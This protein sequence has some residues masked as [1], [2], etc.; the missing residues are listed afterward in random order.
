MESGIPIGKLLPAEKRK[1]YEILDT[2]NFW[3]DLGKQKTAILLRYRNDVFCIFSMIEII[4]WLY[5]ID[6]LETC[7]ESCR[8]CWFET[9][10]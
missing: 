10:I 5:L 8:V 7:C 6:F 4:K 1:I 2:N 3:K 9:R